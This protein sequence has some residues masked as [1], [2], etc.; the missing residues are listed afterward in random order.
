MR[1]KMEG[2]GEEETGRERGR[3]VTCQRE[4]RERSRKR[5]RGN[6]EKGKG[7]DEEGEEGGGDR[8]EGEGQRGRRKER[9]KEGEGEGREGGGKEKGSYSKTRY[10][11]S[12][13]YFCYLPSHPNRKSFTPLDKVIEES[14]PGGLFLLSFSPLYPLSPPSSSISSPPPWPM[15]LHQHPC[16]CVYGRK[17]G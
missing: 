10:K 12:T 15:Y 3:G 14:E 17:G 2:E 9:G 4:L 1:E 13:C 6:E 5:R 7:R 11:I 16:I 8:R